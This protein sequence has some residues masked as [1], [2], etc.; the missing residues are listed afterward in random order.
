MPKPYII[1]NGFF[2]IKNFGDKSKLMENLV[3]IELIRKGENIAYF[4]NEKGEIDFLIKKDKEISSL[5][6][7]CFDITKS[8]TKEREVKLLIKQPENFNCKNLIVLTWDYENEEIIENKKILF[9]PLWKWL[10]KQ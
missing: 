4:S 2:S 10:L 5:I 7:V 1:D 8:E 3:F 6:Q 9:I